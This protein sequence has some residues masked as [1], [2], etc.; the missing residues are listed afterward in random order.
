MEV[1]GN[2]ANVEEMEEGGLVLV[3]E[4]AKDNDII[5]FKITC[6]TV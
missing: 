5:R 4:P 2:T 6:D 3:E 1:H